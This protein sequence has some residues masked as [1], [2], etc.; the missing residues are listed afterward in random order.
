MTISLVTKLHC[1]SSV[2]MCDSW[3]NHSLRFVPV[4]GSK[5]EHVLFA[6]G[7]GKNRYRKP[8]HTRLVSGTSWLVPETGTGNRSM[9][10]RLYAF[11][12]HHLLSLTNMLA[13]RKR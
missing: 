3:T 11:W 2:C 12:L 1:C 9:C 4:A 13:N 8:W 6:A 5:I 7:T 10:H